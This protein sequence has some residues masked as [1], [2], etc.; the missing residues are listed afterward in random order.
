VQEVAVKIAVVEEL[1]SPG[2]N[3]LSVGLLSVV[4]I[5]KQNLQHG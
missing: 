5:L 4:K 1:H 3:V 2:C